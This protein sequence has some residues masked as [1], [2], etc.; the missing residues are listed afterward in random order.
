MLNLPNELDI[1]KLI[2]DLKGVSWKPS[3]IL[4]NYLQNLDNRLRESKFIKTKDNNRS[5]TLAD[6]R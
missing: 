2:D 3:E 4:L 6:L 5:F 1:N